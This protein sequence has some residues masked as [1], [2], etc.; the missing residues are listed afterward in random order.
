[1][2]L[3]EMMLHICNATPYAKFILILI[4]GIFVFFIL[5]GWNRGD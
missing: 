5:S 2:T 3:Y 1:M 4:G